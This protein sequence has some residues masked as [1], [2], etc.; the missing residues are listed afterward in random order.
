MWTERERDILASLV[1]KVRMLS[2]EV[3]LRE[4]WPPSESA[5]T[6]A[7]RRLSELVEAGLLVRERAPARPLLPLAEPVFRWKPG[8]DAPAFGGLSWAMQ[9]RWTEPARDVTVYLATRRAAAIFG[10]KADGRIKNL[11]QVTHDVHLGA[12]YLK[13]RRDAPSLAAGWVGEEIFAPTREHQK[14]P[15]ALLYD[16]EG[17]PRLV[18]EFGGAYPAERVKAFHED[19]AARGLPYELW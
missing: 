2:F 10:G 19:C 4:W 13:F 15:D 5:K 12:L 3:I 1:S 8:Q 7:R 17:R 9:K 16:R 14:L 6:N 11:S 18:V